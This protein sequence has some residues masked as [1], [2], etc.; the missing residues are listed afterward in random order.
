[1]KLKIINAFLAICL[2]TFSG[3]RPSGNN[4]PSNSG[5]NVTDAE[6]KT[7]TVGDA[8]RSKTSRF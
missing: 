2:L 8:S 7:V 1:M 6:G 4:S 3:C 5:V